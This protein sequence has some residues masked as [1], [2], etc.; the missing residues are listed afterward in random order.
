MT[1][2][3]PDTDTVVA[4]CRRWVEQLVIG[5]NLCPFARKPYENGQVR[6][7]VSHATQPEALLEDLHREL[8]TLRS[9]D[10]QELDT[11]LLIHP[12][13]LQDFLDYNDFLGV[14]DNF[15][16]QGG[17]ADEFQVASLHPD[18][19]FADTQPD[20]A[21]NYTNRSPYPLLHILRENSV[22]QALGSIAHPEKIPE[23]NI[24]S[25]EK[26][27]AAQLHEQLAGCL[28]SDPALPVLYTFRR[29]P[30]AMRARLALKYSGIALE[31]REVD[32]KAV[33][34]SL[35]QA[36]AKDTVPVLVLP[37]GKVIDESLD[38]MLWALRCNDPDGWLGEDEGHVLPADR[39]L[40]MND[41]SFKQDLDHYKYAERYPEHTQQEYRAR[42]EEFLQELDDLLGEHDF[43]LGDSVSLADIGIFPFIRQFALVDR[44]WF[45]SAPYRNLQRW[46][47][48]FLQSGLFTAVMLKHPVWKPGDAPVIQRPEYLPPGDG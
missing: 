40:E 6:F 15:L 19:R 47:D 4:H 36:S 12:Q 34:E 7:V 35:S 17:Y 26:L 29:C 24:R 46:L 2:P 38:I 41:F 43:L 1:S 20:D 18:Y 11:T 8:E 32:L 21:E 45:D 16:E 33:P 48:G 13:V 10:P 37:D 25:L 22:T 27:G 42:G 44:D 31:L 28:K 9:T 23:R 14:V 3:R 5:L 39:L 30:Y